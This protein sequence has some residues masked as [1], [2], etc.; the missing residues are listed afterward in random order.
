M[1]KRTLPLQDLVCAP[2][3]SDLSAALFYK[4]LLIDDS[5]KPSYGIYRANAFH[6]HSDRRTLSSVLAKIEK[7]K[8]SQI[9][10]MNNDVTNL[11]YSLIE[12]DSAYA[13]KPKGR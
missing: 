7:V 6:L 11:H 5:Q 9:R 10:K 3:D 1:R 2:Q 4:K 8:N 12:H 13:I